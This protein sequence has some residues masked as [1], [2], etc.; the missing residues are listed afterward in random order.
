M[1]TDRNQ[2]SGGPDA[3]QREAS[4]PHRAPDP[5]RIG[6]YRIVRVLGEGGMGT[7]YEAEQEDPRRRVALKVVR[8]GEVVTEETLQ[9]FRREAQAL[10]LLKH[11]GIAQIYESG[12]TDDGRHFFAMELVRGVTLGEHMA[13]HPVTRTSG[14]RDL[15]ALL[16]LFLQICDAVNYAHQRGVIHRDLKPSNVV[17]VPSGGHG[18]EQHLSMVPGQVKVLDFGIARITDSDTWVTE[19]GRIL[20]TLSYMSPEQ[21]RGN[22]DEVDLRTDVYSLGVLL[23]EMITGELPYRIRTPVVAPHVINEE[24][25][26]PP[27]RV[28]REMGRRMDRD[29]ETIILKALEKEPARRYQSAWA[30]AEDVERYLRGEP[31][32]AR[33]ASGLYQF[34][35]LVR[36]NKVPAAMAAGLVV[37]LAAATVVTAVGRARA[38]AAEAQARAEADK[39]AAINEFLQD[40]LAAPDPRNEG[41]DVRVVDVLE[42][43]ARQVEL[44][45]A[46]QPELEASVRST[47]GRTYMNLGLYEEAEHNFQRALALRRASPVDASYSLDDLAQLLPLAGRFPEAEQAA[48]EALDIRRTTLGETDR[49]TAISLSHLGGIQVRQGRYA[50]AETTLT[51]ALQVGRAAMDSTDQELSELHN[52]LGYFYYEQGR[53]EDAAG[54]FG[55]ALRVVR[56]GSRQPLDVAT[57][58]NNLAITLSTL[59]RYDE[60]EPLY[61]ESLEIHRNAEGEDHPGYLQSLNNLGMFY[62]RRGR[63]DEAE[64]RLREAYEGSRTALGDE[65]PET[66]NYLNNLAQV[67]RD[68]DR[69]VDAEAAWGRVLAIDSAAL[70]P[71]HRILADRLNNL[72]A[73]LVLEGKYTAAERHFLEARRIYVANLGEDHFLVATSNNLL[74]D[75]LAKEGRFEEA[76]PLAVQGYE[77][78]AAAF[79]PE[80]RRTRAAL[81]HVIDMYDAWGRTADAERY[82]A[83]MPG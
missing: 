17:V 55:E 30:F 45:L 37:V 34:G 59:E 60:A 35:K 50:E 5:A 12:S 41:R 61:Q 49:L 58:L 81:Q 19:A 22:P 74:G 65:H 69:L 42:R 66:A 27:S 75:C 71:D 31:I 25:P 64:L 62:Y 26:A 9:L 73:V 77:T 23:Y 48:G 16:S 28:W 38:L 56:A 76:E 44:T 68:T 13:V 51:R 52:T 8:G 53:Y 20:G 24:S 47:L 46:S 67:F 6:H 11:P 80:H 32:L 15:R 39:A 72:G 78:I 63:Y 40:M 18:V 3:S 36:R 7:V 70:G 33:P 57:A 79:P 4:P 29:L 14:E 2:F 82:R 21:V 10:A 83:L 1:P 43:A 54:S